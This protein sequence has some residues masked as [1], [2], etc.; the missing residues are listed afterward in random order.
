[1][2]IRSNYDEQGHCENAKTAILLELRALVFRACERDA[3]LS[4]SWKI[5]H[6]NGRGS[7]FSA[8]KSLG[9]LPGC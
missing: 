9:V 4:C 3:G 2:S 5:L 1:M 6:F 7:T 8:S